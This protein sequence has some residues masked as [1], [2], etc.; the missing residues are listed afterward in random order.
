MRMAYFI[1]FPVPPTL[2]MLE[3]VCVYAQGLPEIVFQK[4]LT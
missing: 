2:P 1:P 3:P 4:T